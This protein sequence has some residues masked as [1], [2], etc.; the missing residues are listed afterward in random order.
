LDPSGSWMTRKQRF[1]QLGSRD[2]R[3]LCDLNRVKTRHRGSKIKSLL[4]SLHRQGKKVIWS[5]LIS[6]DCRSLSQIISFIKSPKS[7]LV[8]ASSVSNLSC[9]RWLSQHFPDRLSCRS[10]NRSW[11]SWDLLE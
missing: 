8:E 10:C 1:F 6:E 7:W 2:R 11:H 9:T 3:G 4:L 5:L